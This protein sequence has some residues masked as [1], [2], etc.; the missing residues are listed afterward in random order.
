MDEEEIYAAMV[1][2]MKNSRDFKIMHSEWVWLN[3]IENYIAPV[4]FMLGEAD[5]KKGSWIAG[6]HIP[7]RTLWTLVEN[8]TLTGFSIGGSAIAVTADPVV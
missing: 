5:I 4:D 7:D 1:E 2:F 6:I 8:G 3:I